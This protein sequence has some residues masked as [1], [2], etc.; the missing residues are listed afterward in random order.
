M[1]NSKHW[2]YYSHQTNVTG[3]HLSE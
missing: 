3:W 1:T 2:Q